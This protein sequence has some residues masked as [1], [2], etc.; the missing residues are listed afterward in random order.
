MAKRPPVAKS[1]LE[2]VQIVWQL[3]EA[4]VRQVLEALPAQRK[5][6]FKTVQTYLR[7]LE[8]KGYLRTRRDGR[9]KL[10]A[11]RVRPD[12]VVR[13]VVDD[14]VHRLFAGESL[15]LFQH[16]IQ[17]RGLTDAEIG[18]LRSMLKELED[19]KP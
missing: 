18:Q 15:P 17:D 4:S 16:L 12:Q 11:P 1:E 2:V 14:L 5:L 19:R 6:D 7:R 10:Y 3:G 13:E 8:A 9:A